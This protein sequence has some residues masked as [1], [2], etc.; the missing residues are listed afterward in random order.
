M[1]QTAGDMDNSDDTESESESESDVIV[2]VDS[3]T[4]VSA[5]SL[6]NISD[7]A[8]D[9]GEEEI[10]VDSLTNTIPETESETESNTNGSRKLLPQFTA[11]E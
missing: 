9:S 8:T 3:S 4:E 11:I 5:I 10:N 7:W 6:T 2:V 1:P